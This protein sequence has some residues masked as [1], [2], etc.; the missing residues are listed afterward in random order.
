MT[1]AALL[2]TLGAVFVEQ[3]WGLRSVAGSIA[4]L[5][6]AVHPLARLAFAALPHV[7]ENC[8]SKWSPKAFLGKTDVLQDI[9]C[10]GIINGI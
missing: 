4:L 8:K 5:S 3:H 10:S 6:G 7:D 2:P 9:R 1:S